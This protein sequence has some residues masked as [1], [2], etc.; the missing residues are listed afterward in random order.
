VRFE[1]TIGANVK[2]IVL[3]CSMDVVMNE[4]PSEDTQR[5]DFEMLHDEIIISRHSVCGLIMGSRN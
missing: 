1:H 3:F 5:T 4:S 2:R